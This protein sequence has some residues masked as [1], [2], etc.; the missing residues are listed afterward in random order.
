MTSPHPHGD[1]RDALRKNA[2]VGSVWAFVLT[3]VGIGIGAG[4]V[5]GGFALFQAILTNEVGK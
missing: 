1:P 3:C 5:L 4:L 2:I